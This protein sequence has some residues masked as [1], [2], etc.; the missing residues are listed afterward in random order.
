MGSAGAPSEP[1]T[2]DPRPGSR[3][4]WIDLP[5][6]F[7]ILRK[8]LGWRVGVDPKDASFP[9]HSCGSAAMNKNA[10]PSDPG[11]TVSY[12]ECRREPLVRGDRAAAGGAGE[13]DE[14]GE[15]GE[16]MT[17]VQECGAERAG[18]CFVC[19]RPCGFYLISSPGIRLGWQRVEGGGQ[20]TEPHIRPQ[21]ACA[22]CVAAGGWGGGGA[23]CYRACTVY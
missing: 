11:L 3:K 20:H 12:R 8:V 22:A 10:D 14:A 2:L 7:P 16:A 23:T 19:D 5:W 18:F 9:M 15:G 17:G 13:E 1:G 6:D 4:A 21:I